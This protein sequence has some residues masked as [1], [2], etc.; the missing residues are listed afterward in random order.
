MFS[1]LLN[2]GGVKYLF[3]KKTIVILLIS[4]FLCMIKASPPVDVL[5]FACQI[6]LDICGLKLNTATL[7]DIF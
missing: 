5:V 1:L 4:V 2:L 6:G 7:Q 3:W